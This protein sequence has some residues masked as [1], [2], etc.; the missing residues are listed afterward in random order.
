MRNGVSGALCLGSP[1]PGQARTVWGDH[2]RFKD[3]YF[4]QYKDKGGKDDRVDQYMKDANKGIEKEERR[5]EREDTRQELEDNLREAEE[6]TAEAQ[7]AQDELRGVLAA[8]LRVDDRVDW[9]AMIQPP[10]S[11]PRPKERPFL[12][13]RSSSNRAST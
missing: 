3:T 11:Q 13:R 10:F 12:R 9:T 2:Q 7:A 6:R 4:T 1:W 8:T 5:R